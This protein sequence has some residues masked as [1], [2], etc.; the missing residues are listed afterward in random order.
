MAAGSLH[1]PQ[2][3]L[4]LREDLTRSPEDSSPP[5]LWDGQEEKKAELVFTTSRFPPVHV[6]GGPSLSTPDSEELDLL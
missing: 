2:S 5:R 4:F 1:C 6:R 3:L